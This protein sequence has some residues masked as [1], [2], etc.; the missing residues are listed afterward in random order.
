MSYIGLRM[1]AR[2][3]YVLYVHDLPS[4]QQQITHVWKPSTTFNNLTI[5]EIKESVKRAQEINDLTARGQT[6]YELPT[7]DGLL[8]ILIK[9]EKDPELSQSSDKNS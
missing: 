5:G 6:Q 8:D 9:E 3:I 2:Q 7:I 4:N 1:Y